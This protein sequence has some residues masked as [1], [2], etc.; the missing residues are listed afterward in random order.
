M[1]SLLGKTADVALL[2]AVKDRASRSTPQRAA[3]DQ[4]PAGQIISQDVVPGSTVDPTANVTVHV[5]VSTGGRPSY[6]QPAAGW[7]PTYALVRLPTPWRPY[8]PP[9]SVRRSS[10]ASTRRERDDRRRRRPGNADHRIGDPDSRS[11]RGPRRPEH[12]H[13]S[14]PGRPRG[15]RLS[16]QRLPVHHHRGCERESCGRSEAGASLA[17]N[18]T[19]TGRQRTS[20]ESS[21]SIRR[22]A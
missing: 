3:S 7:F 11:R 17:P 13:R 4:Y 20:S 22:S 6:H 2:I 8:G 12:D 9:A 16:H 15:Q 18:A 14:S 21:G 19:V 10:T 5:V 1:P